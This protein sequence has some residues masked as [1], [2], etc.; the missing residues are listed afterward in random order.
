MDNSIEFVFSYLCILR[1]RNGRYDIHPTW[2]T[3]RPKEKRKREKQSNLIKKGSECLIDDPQMRIVA[4]SSPRSFSLSLSL[5]PSRSLFLFLPPSFSL[6]LS[7]SLCLSPSL[8]S[9]RLCSR[10]CLL[11]CFCFRLPVCLSVCLSVR[12]CLFL[13][14]DENRFN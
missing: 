4:S 14:T 5:P 2:K 7:L 1:M 9:V 12:S 10:L 13:A 3:R 8:S 6:S 11:V